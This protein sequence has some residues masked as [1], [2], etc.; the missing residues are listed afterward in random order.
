MKTI[1]FI[2]L[3]TLPLFV[4]A[5]TEINTNDYRLRIGPD[6]P[7]KSAF[8]VSEI[9]GHDATG[10][11]VIRSKKRG[12]FGSMAFYKNSGSI[13]EKATFFIEK[14]DYQLKLIKSIDL[15]AVLERGGYEYH[16]IDYQNEKIQLYITQYNYDQKS[17]TLF[18]QAVDKESLLPVGTP[19]ELYRNTDLK[20]SNFKGELYASSVSPNT[21]FNF[22]LIESDIKDKDSRNLVLLS[23][24]QDHNKMWGNELNIPFPK[25]YVDVM[26]VKVDNFNQAHI[27]VKI[28]N[29]MNPQLYQLKIYSIVDNGSVTKEMMLNVPD[30]HLSNI[31]TASFSKNEL[32]CAGFY[33]NQQYSS[34]AGTF[35]FKLDFERQQILEEK[36]EEFEIDF[37]TQF[38]SGKNARKMEKREKKGKDVEMPDYKLDELIIKDDGS[39]LLI[40]EQFRVDVVTSYYGQ[41]GGSTTTY[42]FNYNDIIIVN[43]SKEGDVQWMT[44]IPKA[45]RTAGDEGF[46][47]SYSMIMQDDD[48]YFIYND[49]LDNFLLDDVKKIRN[50]V[51]TSTNSATMISH[52][53]Q[54]GIHK[55]EVLLYNQQLDAVVKPTI[56]RHLSHNEIIL[57][58]HRGSN[59]NFIAVDLKKRN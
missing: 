21:M 28:K 19:I 41:Y 27:L 8:T 11:Y 43:Y 36:F 46:Y 2:L 10:Y 37:I 50:Y 24:D 25:K 15:D 30:K 44:K 3:A 47:S 13:N 56:S 20:S 57:Y 54:D 29:E 18:A 59:Q 17:R 42:Y 34:I 32:V 7:S 48:L 5:Q 33:S 23:F 1:F 31:Q 58:A 22:L 45:Q 53:D 26:S 6:L 35:Y 38:M 52:I 9:F 16:F 40:A 12:L 4:V 49:N 51:P 14:Y 39:I 55:K